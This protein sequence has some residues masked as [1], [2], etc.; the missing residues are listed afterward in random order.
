MNRKFHRSQTQSGQFWRRG[1]ATA[2]IQTLHPVASHYTNYTLLAR[3]RV[4][5]CVGI[6]AHVYMF[7]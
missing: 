7:T 6:C 4:C 1:N 2:W 3:V 5:L